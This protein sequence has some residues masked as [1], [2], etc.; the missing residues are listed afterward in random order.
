[1]KVFCATQAGTMHQ[2]YSTYHNKHN[3]KTLN[4]ISSRKTYKARNILKLMSHCCLLAGLLSM[5]SILLLSTRISYSHTTLQDM[6]ILCPP[7]STN[8]CNRRTHVKASFSFGQQN[9]SSQAISHYN[10]SDFFDCQ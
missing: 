7:Q 2:A 5:T 9:A 10:Q 6:E 3:M 4:L 1:M 8:M